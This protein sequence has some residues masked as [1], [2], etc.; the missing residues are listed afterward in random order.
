MEQ[1]LYIFLVFMHVAGTI[2]GVGGA[3]LAEVFHV[4]ALSDGKV[5]ADEK[6]LMH[7]NYKVI[8]IGL[9]LIIVSGVGLLWWWVFMGNNDWP[10]T[11]PKVWLK[12]LLTGIIL[13]N[14]I[15]LTKRMVPM[16]LGA[17]LSFTSWWGATFLG[18]WRHIPYTFWEMFSVYVI[19]VFVMAFVL[20]VIR[21]T[22]WKHAK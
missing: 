6:A 5:H 22:H 4:K 9:L 2:L 3:T 13:V 20:E 15:L 8:R 19:A 7:A 1:A 18:V 21:R 11:A 10:L 14:A 12:D 17:S 16:W